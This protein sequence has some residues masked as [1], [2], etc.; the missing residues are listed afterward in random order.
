MTYLRN[1]YCAGPVRSGPVRSGPVRSGP[2]RSGPVRSGPVRSGPVRS[3]PVRSGAIWMK[4]ATVFWPL[5]RPCDRVAIHWRLLL[6]LSCTL[7][8]CAGGGDQVRGA[9]GGGQ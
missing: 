9:G 6:S 1:V 4:S 3:G 5:E 7:G 8:V 2:V